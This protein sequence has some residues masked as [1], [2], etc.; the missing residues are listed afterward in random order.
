MAVTPEQIR[1]AA[2][3]MI[4][5]N[6]IVISVVGDAAKIKQDLEFF[7]PVQVY[8]TSGALSSSADKVQNDAVK[9][10]SHSWA[11]VFSSTS[12]SVQVDRFIW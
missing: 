3:R 12:Y 11:N 8:D 4:D 7:G 6:N 9:S 10:K 5:L 2:R 1:S